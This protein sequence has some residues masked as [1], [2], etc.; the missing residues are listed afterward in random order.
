ML[1]YESSAFRIG[2]EYP[3]FSELFETVHRAKRVMPSYLQLDNG[4]NFIGAANELTELSAIL[5]SIY[6]A[7]YRSKSHN[8]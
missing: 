5:R 7:I 2:Y 6:S 3:S 8:Y 1:F 4:I